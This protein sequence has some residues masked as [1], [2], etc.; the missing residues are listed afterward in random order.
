MKADPDVIASRREL[1]SMKDATEARMLTRP[2]NAWHGPADRAKPYLLVYY[3][4]TITGESF[5][6]SRSSL[7]VG[8]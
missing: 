8:Y 1:R 7:A 2:T 6:M 4:N 3:K 5:F